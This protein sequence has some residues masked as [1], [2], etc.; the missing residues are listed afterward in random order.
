MKIRLFSFLISLFYSLPG[1]SELLPWQTHVDSTTRQVFSLNGQWKFRFHTDPETQWRTIEVPGSWDL[2]F[3]DLFNK[4]GKATYQKTFKLPQ[5]FKGA[6]KRLVFEGVFREATVKLN[7]K[8][9]G[10]LNRP[11]LPA[12]FDVSSLLRPG[13]NELTLEIDNRI[14]YR[15]IPTNTIIYH[16]NKLGWMPYGGITRD[17]RIEA[18]SSVYPSKVFIHGDQDGTLRGKITFAG[19]TRK[20][21]TTSAW[22]TFDKKKILE[23]KEVQ[24]GLDVKL[25]QVKLWTPET[26]NVYELH[27]KTTVD[28]NSETNTYQF[29]FKKFE[30]K[31]QKFFLNGKPIFLKGMNRHEEH[32]VWGPVYRKDILELDVQLMKELN[33]NFL[34]PGHYPNHPEVL[35]EV[36]KAGIMI[37]EEIPVYQ[38]EFHHFLS[39]DMEKLALNHLEGMITRDFN[40]PGIVMWSVANEIHNWHS[41]AGKFIRKLYQRS[42]ELDPHRPVMVAALTLPPI[43]QQGLLKDESS[44]EVD[45]IGINEYFGWY[46]GDIQ[47]TETILKR[48]KSWFPEKTIFISEFGADAISGKHGVPGGPEDNSDHSFTEEFQ[49]WFIA[50]HMKLYQKL[51]FIQGTMPWIFSDFRFQWT[52]NT[53]KNQIPLMNLKGLVDSQRKKKKAFYVIKNAYK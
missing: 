4:Q 36:E 1:Y 48:Y 10:F 29:A 11:Y 24:K 40:R 47:D 20:P 37:A 8:V 38:W 13:L 27:L 16:R 12:H 2:Q 39:E 51:P 14:H 23:F 17:V 41:S 49:E 46:T 25:D 45:A 31:E 44:G 30:A 22:I 9:L 15:S 3:K 50:E 34:R 21:F 7:G 18:G 32:P 33:V 19:G 52:L 43:L 26:P 5:D 28:D 6:M 35:K 53:G 42:K